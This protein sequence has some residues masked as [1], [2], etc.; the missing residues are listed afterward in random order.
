MPLTVKDPDCPRNWA[1]RHGRK[2]SSIFD[3]KLEM[4]KRQ[5]AT[6]TSFNAEMISE[7]HKALLK[8]PP[9]Y[10]KGMLVDGLNE[11]IWC[12]RLTDC[13]KENHIDDKA[14]SPLFSPTSGEHLVTATEPKRHASVIWISSILM[15]FIRMDF[16]YLI[17]IYILTLAT[18]Q[19]IYSFEFPLLFIGP[20]LL[21]IHYNH[22][23]STPHWIELFLLLLF[24]YYSCCCF[25]FSSYRRTQRN[26][27]SM[28]PTPL[29]LTKCS[30]IRYSKCEISPPDRLPYLRRNN[31]DNNFVDIPVPL[32]G[33]FIKRWNIGFLPK[34]P[35]ESPGD[36]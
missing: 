12:N 28:F 6:S 7:T 1:R 5:I 34:T 20:I 9:P 31:K 23:C 33:N 35:T 27:L 15:K 22:I 10:S 11:F 17:N 3:W 8:P 19:T 32:R 21:C 24:I 26:I 16:H 18:F 30:I 25:R 29:L 13:S 4:A 2:T 36:T 14:T